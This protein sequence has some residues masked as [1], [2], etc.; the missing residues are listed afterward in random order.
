MHQLLCKAR[1]QLTVALT[2]YHALDLPA[3]NLPA[4]K[5]HASI[6]KIVRGSLPENENGKNHGK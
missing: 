1:N 2:M 5:I 4:E 3:E 6:N